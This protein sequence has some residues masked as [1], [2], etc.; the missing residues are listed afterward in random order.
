MT[1]LLEYGYANGNA[2]MATSSQV[3]IITAMF[4]KLKVAIE[5]K[6]SKDEWDF[7]IDAKKT[8]AKALG[9]GKGHRVV[10]AEPHHLARNRDE[11]VERL[12]AIHALGSFLVEAKTGRSTEDPAECPRLVNNTIYFY[13]TGLSPERRSELA[14]HAAKFS[15]VAKIRTD[16]VPNK[17]AAVHLNNMA[18]TVQEAIALINGTRDANGKRYR[19]RWTKEFAYRERRANPK[20]IDF[21]NRPAGPP[22]KRS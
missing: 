12:A 8:G 9:R 19:R 17:I 1:Q 7:L 4:P 13:E 14:A 18:L 5:Q 16:R 15:P 10:V 20:R 3:E 2:K 6:G 21:P 22:V 11:F